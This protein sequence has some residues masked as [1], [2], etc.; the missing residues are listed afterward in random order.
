M[1]QQRVHHSHESESFRSHRVGVGTTYQAFSSR[2]SD[3]FQGAGEGDP[4]WPR[5][6]AEQKDGVRRRTWWRLRARLR[7][8][9]FH[10]LD[11]AAAH[12]L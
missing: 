5:A 10:L 1:Y 3:Y 11:P 12:R 8:V 9:M 4:G 7:P 6:C 2:E